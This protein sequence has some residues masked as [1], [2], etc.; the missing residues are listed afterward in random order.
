MK[1]QAIEGAKIMRAHSV[2]WLKDVAFIVEQYHER[3]DGKGYPNCLKA[4]KGTQ[5]NP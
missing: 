1:S 2:V 4:G 5:F 3:Y